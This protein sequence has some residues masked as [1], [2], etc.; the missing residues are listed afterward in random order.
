MDMLNVSVL[1]RT[2]IG[3]C[4][5]SAMSIDSTSHDSASLIHQCATAEAWV[6]R[7][8]VPAA[9]TATMSLLTGCGMNVEV[10]MVS[11]LWS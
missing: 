8:R 7:T 1:N 2:W 6:A 5:S 9:V 3:N 11:F 4:S 10:A